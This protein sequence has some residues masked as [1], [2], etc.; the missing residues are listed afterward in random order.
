MH[1][2]KSRPVDGQRTRA[3]DRPQHHQRR[4]VRGLAA[5]FHRH[6]ARAARGVG[7]PKDIGAVGAAGRASFA[8]GTWTIEGSGADI[9][10]TADEFRYGIGQVTGKFSLTARV[11]SIENRSLGQGRDHAGR[12]LAGLTPHALFATP[13]TERGLAFQR[14]LAGNAYSMHTAGPAVGHRYG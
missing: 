7:V 1:V 3:G 9:W 5:L 13:R 8:N 4:L 6:G 2:E 14:R 12:T 10:D 11:A